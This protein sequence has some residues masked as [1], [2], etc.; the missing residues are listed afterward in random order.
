M[1]RFGQLYLQDGV[2]N[3]HRILPAGWVAASTSKIADTSNA[4]MQLE[5][6]QGYGYQ[7]W[8]GRGGSYCAFGLGGQFILVVP[9]AQIVLATTANTL[10]N[11]DEHQLILDAFWQWIY[12][13]CDE[14]HPS[15]DAS[16]PHH[17]PSMH[18]PP[19]K[20]AQ[21]TVSPELPCYLP[22]G[23]NFMPPACAGAASKYQ[24]AA[25]KLGYTSCQFH[26][27]ERCRLILYA[28]DRQVECQFALGRSIIGPD[29]FLSRPSGAAAGWVNERTLVLHIQ[30]LDELQMFILT[31]C[32]T[33]DMLVIQIKPIGVLDT[34]HLEE[35][36]TG[37]TSA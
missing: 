24:L 5:G 3:G 13:V 36:L 21:S 1:A 14:A 2:W 16:H 26:W 10:Q 6:R 32:F 11:R 29:P 4:R 33:A 31:C 23:V 35:D 30:L 7:F 8:L 12:P 22:D 25:N 15:L 17:P 19:L 37:S 18:E 27:G 28:E 9:E 20:S 34:G